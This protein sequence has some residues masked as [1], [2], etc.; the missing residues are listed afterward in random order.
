MLA[1]EWGVRPSEVLDEPVWAVE[2]AL[3]LMAARAELAE[4]AR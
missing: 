3:A 1:R 4:E 2:A